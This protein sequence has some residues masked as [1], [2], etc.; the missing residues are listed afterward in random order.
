MALWQVSESESASQL[1]HCALQALLPDTARLELGSGSSWKTVPASVVSPGN[2]V[3]VLPGDC[4]PADGQVVRGRSSVDE[5][6]L[7]GEPMPVTKQAG[8]AAY[9]I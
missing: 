2:V 7:T 4:I 6:A 1:S 5:S 9:F 3:R 8:G